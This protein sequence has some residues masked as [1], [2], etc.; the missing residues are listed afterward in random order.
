MIRE[1]SDNH[2]QICMNP[3]PYAVQRQAAKDLVEILTNRKKEESEQEEEIWESVVSEV[4]GIQT[5]KALPGTINVTA[6]EAS[7][8]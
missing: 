8:P 7:I 3:V 1:Q 6:T 5:R 4:G 2:R